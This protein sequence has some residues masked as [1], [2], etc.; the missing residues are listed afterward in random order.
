MTTCATFAMT[1]NA[2]LWACDTSVAVAALDPTHEAH[3]ACRRAL[4]ELR[5]ALAGHATFE[6]YSV[7]TRLP[8]PLRLTA[9]QAG[10]VLAGL[11]RKTVGS[12][13]L[14]PAICASDLPAST[15]SADRSMTPSSAKP[16]LPTT[17]PFSH[18][19]VGLSAPTARSISSTGSWTDGRPASK[20]WHSLRRHPHIADLITSPR[21]LLQSR[22][23]HWG[24]TPDANCALRRRTEDD[25][26]PHW[27]RVS[28]NGAV[29][30]GRRGLDSVRL[31]DL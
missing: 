24:L 26:T 14:G 10:S 3:P 18:V 22:R 30:R 12:M 7:L 19:T 8:L 5:P 15:L 1:P 29:D 17:A 2:D 25:L 27:R 31:S 16:L 28:P 20:R 13:Q 23:R 11:F 4:V 6:T 9:V 21:V